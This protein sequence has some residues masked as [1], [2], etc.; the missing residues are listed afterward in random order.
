MDELDRLRK[1]NE[2]MRTLIETIVNLSYSKN[3][4]KLKKNSFIIL[5]A[6]QYLK[7]VCS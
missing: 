2:N 7:N 6:K 5:I 4:A 1:E 3:G